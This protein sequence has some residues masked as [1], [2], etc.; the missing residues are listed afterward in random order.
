MKLDRAFSAP[1][2]MARHGESK[3]NRFNRV[4]GCEWDVPLTDK[5]CEQAYE[6]AQTILTMDN[7]PTVIF[8]SP[9][10][11]AF[12]TASIVASEIGADVHM[13]YDLREQG[14]GSWN[15]QKYYVL[16]EQF[17]RGDEPQDG[18]TQQAYMRRVLMALGQMQD[19]ASALAVQSPPLVV[20][21]GG[22][23]YALAQITKTFHGMKEIGN[24][25]LYRFG[26]CQIGDKRLFQVQQV[27]VEQGD[28]V[29]RRAPFSPR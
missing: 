15:K 13:I 14:L 28:A 3:A 12:K 2:Y 22:L 24:C 11:R 8:S 1:F 19:E 23:F 20:A 27:L 7:K 21:H 10:Q 29:L 9:L 16:R 26:P 18:E 6:L 25:S 17:E 5:G 4:A